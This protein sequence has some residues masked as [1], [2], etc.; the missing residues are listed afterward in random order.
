MVQFHKLFF[1]QSGQA[2]IQYLY[3]SPGQWYEK[4]CDQLFS[5]SNL[6]NFQFQF[7]HFD[8]VRDTEIIHSIDSCEKTSVGSD[9]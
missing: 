7:F 3:V 9:V 6:H 1:T 2:C 4:D 5:L 8:A